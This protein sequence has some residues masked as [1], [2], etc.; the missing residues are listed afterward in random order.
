MPAG[1]RL[2][3]AMAAPVEGH[4]FGAGVGDWQRPPLA[5]QYMTGFGR[6]AT[7]QDEQQGTAWSLPSTSVAMNPLQLQ[8][9]HP[10]MMAATGV[11]VPAGAAPPT[12]PLMSAVEKPQPFWVSPEMLDS[13]QDS[14]L[15]PSLA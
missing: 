13:R 14:L 11:T 1:G 5:G 15:R 8:H 4:A 10:A 7:M 3:P 6:G 2:G 12:M 9:L